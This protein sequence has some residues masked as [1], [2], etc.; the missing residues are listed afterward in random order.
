LIGQ[1]ERLQK[2]V[3][4]RGDKMNENYVKEFKSF[5]LHILH[6]NSKSDERYKEIKTE[7]KLRIGFL[8]FNFGKK[9]IS[10]YQYE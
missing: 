5:L 6:L 3:D 7:K 10:V 1:L 8:G 2:D 9:M 4:L